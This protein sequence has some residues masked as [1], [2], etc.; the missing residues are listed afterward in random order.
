MRTDDPNFVVRNMQPDEVDMI[1]TW[2]TAEGWNP[3]IH[4]G[5]CFFATDPDGFFVGDLHGQPVSCISCVAYDRSFGFLGRY[6]VKPEF[7]GLGY[8]LQTW[9][10]GLASLGTRSIGLDGVQA[11]QG[12]YRRSG[13]SVAHDHVRYRAEG[14]GRSPAGVVPLSTV[15]FDDVLAYD[16]HCFPAPRPTFLRSW[17][18]LPESVALGCLREGRLAGFG[19]ALRCVEGIRIGPLFA[20]DLAASEK[21]LCGLTA[22]TGGGPFYLDTPDDAENPAAGQLVGRFGM[23]EVFRVARMYTR[24]RPRLNTGR[25]FGI[26]SM[27]LG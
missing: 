2:E 17:L 27:E 6:I 16:R 23:K 12:N 24:G 25:I 11:Q 14:G 10:A 4:A 21:L 7:R 13:F 20:D 9:R 1:R 26:T 19:V 5:P 22:H 15:P 8:G 3:G 18:A